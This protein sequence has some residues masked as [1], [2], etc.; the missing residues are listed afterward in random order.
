M[1]KHLI[2]WSRNILGVVLM[3]SLT[4]SSWGCNNGNWELS[5]QEQAAQ[6]LEEGY[7]YLVQAVYEPVNNVDNLNKAL[8]RV[9][10][11][12]ELSPTHEAMLLKPNIEFLLDWADD[13]DNSLNQVHT[14]YPNE[15]EDE[16]IRAQFL[17]AKMED[18]KEILNNLKIA[19]NDNFV[20]MGEEIWWESIEKGY[21]FD[22]FRNHP[23]YNELLDLKGTKTEG[24]VIFL[25]GCKE[26]VT[27]FKTH[28]WGP[29][30]YV[31]N[32][33]LKYITDTYAFAA[34]IAVFVPGGQPVALAIAIVM[35]WES[36]MIGH[37]DKGCGV[38]INWTWAQFTPGFLAPLAV[39]WVT[40]QK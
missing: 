5:L 4:F 23:E 13:A 12:I 15:G 7:E 37:K 11:S 38:K 40:S 33:D 29:Q 39:F 2:C 9:K 22:H 1:L 28:W 16:Y 3:V 27:K 18:P 19:L 14:Q 32:S 8:E 36:A 26:N 34:T 25:G 21:V 30:L 24:E 35:G 17:S 10:N 6:A 20:G 31:K